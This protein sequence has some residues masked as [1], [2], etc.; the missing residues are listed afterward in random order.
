MSV[1]CAQSFEVAFRYGEQTASH[2]GRSDGIVV[3]LAHFILLLRQAVPSKLHI[4]IE[5]AHTHATTRRILVFE[6]IFVDYVDHGR[7][8]VCLVKFDLM[9]KWF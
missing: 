9:E 4:P 2:C 6:R 1:I 5:T 8:H 3:R 7:D